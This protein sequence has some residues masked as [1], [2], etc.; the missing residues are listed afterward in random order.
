[1][2]TTPAGGGEQAAAAGR[3]A[4]ETWQRERGVPGDAHWDAMPPAAQEAWRATAR[5]VLAAAGKAIT[6]DEARQI[7][8]D[9]LTAQMRPVI[10]AQAA[11]LEALARADERAKLQPAID[12]VTR[13]AAAAQAKAV[14]HAV[15]AERER[16]ARLATSEAAKMRAS[17]FAEH[18]GI[19]AA[20]LEDF[21]DLIR[22]GGDG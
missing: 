19:A 7:M 17:S 10:E 3:L 1:M 15:A 16:I 22:E 14:E 2:S 4:Y 21:A 6:E 13:L 8:Q 18:E 11:E 9:T 5:A 20:S 12:R